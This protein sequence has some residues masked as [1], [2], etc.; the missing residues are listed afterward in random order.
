MTL[1]LISSSVNL[2]NC[3]PLSIEGLKEEFN[4]TMDTFFGFF[5]DAFSDFYKKHPEICWALIAA[6]VLLAVL[7]CM[8]M[9]KYI[10]LFLILALV[11]IAISMFIAEKLK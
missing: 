5:G 2:V 6:A 11:I 4:E 9:F 8:R 3:F 10:V 7:L 1:L